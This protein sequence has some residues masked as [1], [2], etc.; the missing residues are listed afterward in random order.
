MNLA[1]I[2]EEEG[3]EIVDRALFHGEAARHVGLAEIE[4]GVHG[5]LA[6]P[7]PAGDA[8]DDGCAGAVA[9]GVGQAGGI[10]Q[11][12]GPGLDDEAQA[13]VQHGI[14]DLNSRPAPSLAGARGPSIV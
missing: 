7:A 1:G 9:I 5:D 4:V 14:H 6:H 8:E 12:Q 3:E 10:D 13:P 2:V 11:L